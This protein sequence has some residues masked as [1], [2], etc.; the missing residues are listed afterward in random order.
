MRESVSE[1]ERRLITKIQ[2]D[3]KA[4]ILSQMTQGKVAHGFNNE[5]IS[6]LHW[7]LDQF[8]RSSPEPD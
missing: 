5:I 3:N 8:S 7:G 1:G 4:K 2:G 6:I